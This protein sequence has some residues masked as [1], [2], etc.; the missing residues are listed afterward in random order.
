MYMTCNIPWV[1][2]ESEFPTGIK[3]NANPLTLSTAAVLY[4]KFFKEAESTNYD[5]FV[6]RKSLT[7]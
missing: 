5:K 3:L 2:K 6:S 1:N 4:H 7:L